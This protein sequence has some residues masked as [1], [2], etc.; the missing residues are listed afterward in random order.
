[1]Q[2]KILYKCMRI[3]IGKGPNF[4]RKDVLSHS[5]VELIQAIKLVIPGT[6]RGTSGQVRS[7]AF[8]DKDKT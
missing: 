5:I 2:H 1:M 4:E 7:H 8:I 6:N 3:G